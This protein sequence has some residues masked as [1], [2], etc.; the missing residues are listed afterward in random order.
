LPNDPAPAALQSLDAGNSALN[1]NRGGREREHFRN[2]RSGPGKRQ[3]KEPRFRWK[4]LRRPKKSSPF[5]GVEV[6]ATPEITKKIPAEPVVATFFIMIIITNSTNSSMALM[7]GGITMLFKMMVVVPLPLLPTAT[8][9]LLPVHDYAIISPQAFYAAIEVKS[10]LTLYREMSGTKT[11]SPE[12]PL[13]QANKDSYRWSGTMVDAFRNIAALSKVIGD[14]GEAF[15]NGV[16]TYQMSFEWH[17]LYRAFDNNEIQRQLGISH[18]DQLPT[19]ICVPAGLVI[20]LSPY[21]FQE[22]MP[23]HDGSTS[24]FNVIMA[25]ET[26]PGY[27]LQF[28]TTYYA[29]RINHKLTGLK[30]DRGGLLSAVGARVK[31]RSDHFDLNSEG[32][33]DQ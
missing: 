2:A 22:K 20:T 17:T 27:P 33:E 12:Y 28:F 29:N 26:H 15:F 3:A 13:Q 21:D 8:V 4:S 25:T 31:L 5:P 11:A 18:V 32:Y 14:H 10:A 9:A 19:T 7:M 24:L 1:V 16:F 30:P 6:F 23:H